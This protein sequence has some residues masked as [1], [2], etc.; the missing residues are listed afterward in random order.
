VVDVS[1]VEAVPSLAAL[2]SA[3]KAGLAEGFDEFS[4]PVGESV[5][6]QGDFAYELFVIVEGTARVEQDGEVVATLG[7]GEVCGEIGLLLTGRR[8]ATIVAES[9]MVV[10]AMFEQTFRAL[11]RE[12]PE[13]AD[14]VHRQ[15]RGRF[16]R[17]AAV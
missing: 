17:P 1:R 16:T 9:P 13:L 11:S 4:V 5:A 12:H 15:S 10:L 2:S 3:V 14:A 6:N 7:P 8:T